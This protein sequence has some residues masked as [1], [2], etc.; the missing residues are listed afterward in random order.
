MNTAQATLL[1][2]LGGSAGAVARFA[3]VSLVNALMTRASDAPGDR[4]PMGTMLVNVAGCLVI[5]AIMG[6]H[7]AGERAPGDA[8]RLLVIVGFLGS[9]TTFSAFG[10]ET[11]RLVQEDRPTL[12]IANVALSL[13]LGLGAVLLGIVIGRWLSPGR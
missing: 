2:A 12:A 3:T 10:A 4:L 11:I 6:W 9:F 7:Q 8:L 1:V 13:L 5:G